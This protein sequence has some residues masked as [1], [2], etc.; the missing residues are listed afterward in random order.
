MASSNLGRSQAGLVTVLILAMILAQA[1]AQALLLLPVLRPG[2]LLG[3]G[4][5]SPNHA[6]LAPMGP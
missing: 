2:Q 6:S 3:L 5:Q 1:L 4:A